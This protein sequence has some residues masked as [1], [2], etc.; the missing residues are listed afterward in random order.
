MIHPMNGKQYAKLYEKGFRP[1]GDPCA[2]CAFSPM[3][4]PTHVLCGTAPKCTSANIAAPDGNWI[5]VEVN[6]GN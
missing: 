5:W 6:H 2:K 3:T 1:S 4:D